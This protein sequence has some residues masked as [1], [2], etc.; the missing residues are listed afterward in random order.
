MERWLDEQSGDMPYHIIGSVA[1]VDDP[2]AAETGYPVIAN[3]SVSKRAT[4]GTGRTGLASS[5]GK[6]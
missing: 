4:L 5:F 2:S 1:V 6:N 3:G